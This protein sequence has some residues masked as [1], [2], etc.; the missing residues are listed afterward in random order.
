MAIVMVLNNYTH[1]KL[2]IKTTIKVNQSNKSYTVKTY[3]VAIFRI[4]KWNKTNKPEDK[5]KDQPKTPNK[6]MT[7]H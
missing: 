1:E 6:Q 5:G 2:E 7:T 4:V 3:K